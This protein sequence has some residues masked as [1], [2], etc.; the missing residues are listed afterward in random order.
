MIKISCV[1][2]LNVALS[3]YHFHLENA[4]DSI[5]RYIVVTVIIHQQRN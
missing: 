2:K 4:A 5:A 1:L 3:R